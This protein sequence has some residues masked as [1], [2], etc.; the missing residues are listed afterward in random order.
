MGNSALLV[1]D[2]QQSN[3][4]RIQDNA[5]LPR[6]RGSIDAAHA[7]GIPVIYVVIG[8][9]P[10][11]PEVSSQNKAYSSTALTSGYAEGEPGARIHP[12]IAPRPGDVVV[13]KKRFSA[14]SGN[15][16]DMVLRAGSIDH[17]VLAGIATRGV[18]LSTVCEATDLDF[19]LT[20]LVDGCLDPDPEVHR[21]LTEKV[22]PLRADVVTVD[23][24]I[25]SIGK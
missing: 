12:D 13:T 16:L 18:V 9:R 4:D 1:M 6:L 3:V 14:F 24:W 21:V 5:Y 17:L 22:F 23:E 11:F 7:A 20:V 25:R 10:G 2:V 19:G 8:F 15:D